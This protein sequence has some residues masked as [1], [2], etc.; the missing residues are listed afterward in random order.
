MPFINNLDPIPINLS[1]LASKF[2]PSQPSQEASIATNVTDVT[3]PFIESIIETINC[4]DK[5]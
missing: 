4:Q 3:N 1:D 2:D 5:E